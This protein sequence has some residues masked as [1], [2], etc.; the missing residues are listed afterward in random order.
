MAEDSGGSTR[1]GF[2]WGPLEVYRMARFRGT[3]VLGIAVNEKNILE[4][5]VSPSGRRV[6][7][8]KNGREMK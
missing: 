3:R 1:F 4:V 7:V 5:S 8:W 2:W 6:R